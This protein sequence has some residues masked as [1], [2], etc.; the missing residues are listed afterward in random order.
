MTISHK[1]ECDMS[2]WSE[3]VEREREELLHA[4]S[5][6]YN[7]AMVTIKLSVICW[8]GVKTLKKNGKKFYML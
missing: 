2:G 6:V 4:V 1:T 7:V 8:G 5:L 3:D